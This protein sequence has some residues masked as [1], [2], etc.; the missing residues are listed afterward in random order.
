[1]SG[2]QRKMPVSIIQSLEFA[3]H[4]PDTRTLTRHIG[5]YFYL[6]NSL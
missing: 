1:M 4:S 3:F 2:L 6:T 5:M